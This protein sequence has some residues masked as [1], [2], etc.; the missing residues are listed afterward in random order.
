MPSPDLSNVETLDASQVGE[1]LAQPVDEGSLFQRLHGIFI[2]EGTELAGELRGLLPDG[3]RSEIHDLFHKLKGSS[4][5][6]GAKR[7]HEL[8]AFAVSV[9][10]E[11]GDLGQLLDLPDRIEAEYGRYDSEARRYL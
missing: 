6:M 1:L 7:V 8:A 11:D 3:D 5:A 2:A 4:A 9:C 10:R